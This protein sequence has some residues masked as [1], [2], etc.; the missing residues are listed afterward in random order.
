MLS[1]HGAR[2]NNPQVVQPLIRPVYDLVPL[3][4]P[5]RSVCP[6]NG[7]SAGGCRALFAGF[8][9]SLQDCARQA[10]LFA[11]ECLLLPTLT[12]FIDSFYRQGA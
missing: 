9:L 7:V 3:L 12:L 1:S 6:C 2:T 11:V 5:G 8:H 10:L 4:V